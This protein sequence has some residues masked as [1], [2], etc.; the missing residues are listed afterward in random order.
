MQKTFL[1]LTIITFMSISIIAQPSKTKF[2][3]ADHPAFTYQGRIDFSNPKTPRLWAAGTSVKVTFT[4]TFCDLEIQDEVLYGTYHNY[5]EISIDGKE[6]LRIQTK[7]KENKI[8]VAENLK[9]GKHTLIISKGTEALIGHITFVGLHCESVTKSP[10]LNKRKIEFIG[11]SITSG[12]GSI[13]TDIPC[14]SGQ[15]YD[16]HSAWYSYA[17]IAAR[18]LQADYHLTSESGIGLIHSCCDKP[19]TMPQVF[20]KVN[21]AKDSI[22]WNFSSYQPD[23]VSIC[24]GQNDGIQDSLKFTTAYVKFINTIRKAY[25]STQIICL[26]SP[27]ADANLRHKLTNYLKGV[28]QHCKAQG[29]ARIDY[30]TFQKSYNAGC[31]AHP[32]KAEHIQIATELA[33]YLKKKM[34]W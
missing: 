13:T 25:P 32:D 26:T 9:P 30:H 11:D 28:V 16:Q 3:P 17:S 8:R 29:E 21:L 22:K 19:F 34:K 10:I 6:P 2:F 1:A 33:A 7:G 14:D 27:M 23:L 4:G 20:N 12:M 31:G 18:T 24:L 15:W 5:L